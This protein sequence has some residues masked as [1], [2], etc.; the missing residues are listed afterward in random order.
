MCLNRKKWIYLPAEYN[1]L[2]VYNWMWNKIADINQVYLFKE[3]E[4]NEFLF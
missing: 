2:H 1:C 4:I 3:A